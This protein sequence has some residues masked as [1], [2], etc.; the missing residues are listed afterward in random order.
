MTLQEKTDS[1]FSKHY[2]M[3]NVQRVF[4]TIISL[5]LIIIS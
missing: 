1:K 4:H 3:G 5:I 2:G